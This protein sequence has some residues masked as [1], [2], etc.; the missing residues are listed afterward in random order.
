MYSMARAER[1]LAY[2]IAA[3]AGFV[4]ATGFLAADRYF[5]SFM[6]GNTTR[7]GV[8]AGLGSSAAFPAAALI[9]GFVLGVATGALLAERTAGRRRSA[10][11]GLSCTFLA[12]AAMGQAAGSIAVFL[13]GSVLAMGAINNVFRKDGEVALGVT[14][15]TGALVR[16][17]EGL[18]GWIGGSGRGR[19]GVLPSLL[20][21]TSLAAGAALGALA[22]RFGLPAV[23]WLSVVFMLALLAFAWRME[24]RPA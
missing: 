11:L 3:A 17:G 16:V 5:V 4:D 10:V 18:A 15:M 7:L 8:E 2:G 12:I 1:L 20:L 9:V 14:Y 13:G 24:A 19:K 22:S 6:S 21:W 23:P